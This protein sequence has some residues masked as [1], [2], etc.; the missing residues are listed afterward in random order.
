[1]KVLSIND[2]EGNLIAEDSNGRT[3]ESNG[4]YAAITKQVVFRSRTISHSVET[5]VSILFIRGQG[6][7]NDTNVWAN[8]IVQL[9]KGDVCDITNTGDTNLVYLIFV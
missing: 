8:D 7:I 2:I 1:M 3:W 6:K 5:F 9:R 4:D